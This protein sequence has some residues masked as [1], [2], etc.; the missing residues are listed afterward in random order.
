MAA[1]IP[2]ECPECGGS[3]QL[4]EG[5]MNTDPYTCI[6]CGHNFNRSDG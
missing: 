5:F 6:D 4:A 2:D 1:G 3:V